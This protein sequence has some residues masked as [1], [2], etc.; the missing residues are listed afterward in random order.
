M[1]RSLCASLWTLCLSVG[2]LTGCGKPRATNP[3]DSAAGAG[4]GNFFPME[5][6]RTWKYSGSASVQFSCCGGPQTV[7]FEQ[8]WKLARE[9]LRQVDI[10]GKASGTATVSVLEVTHR[11]L[12]YGS[13]PAPAAIPVS[14]HYL[15]KFFYVDGGASVWFIVQFATD[16]YGSATLCLAD[17]ME[18][19]PHVAGKSWET[20]SCLGTRV[21][22]SAKASVNATVAGKSVSA[23][24][25]DAAFGPRLREIRF[26]E[27]LGPVRFERVD[28]DPATTAVDRNWYRFPANW[29]S[30]TSLSSDSMDLISTQ[31]PS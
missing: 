13:L 18:R 12:S 30:L 5:V 3:L 16:P 23:L 11:Y 17:L 6:G 14:T 8:D 25:V 26:A 29:G 9:E 31:A 1:K 27:D 7:T 20:A 22:S 4:R 10:G 28:F 15:M 2:F 21:Q 24:P 19:L